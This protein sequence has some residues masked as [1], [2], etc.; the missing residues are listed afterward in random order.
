MHIT[1]KKSLVKSIPK[2]FSYFYVEFDE[3]DGFCQILENSF[4]RNFAIDTLGGI[5]HLDPLRMQQK[6]SPDQE[7]KN[8]SAFLERW[9]EHDWTLAL[10]EWA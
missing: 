8:V 6:V 5:M 4:P 2:D 1:K 3:N 7:R 9:K 10:D